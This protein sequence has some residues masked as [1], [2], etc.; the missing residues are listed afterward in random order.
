MLIHHLN[1]IINQTSSNM[2]GSRVDS[3]A[4]KIDRAPFSNNIVQTH[5]GLC[6]SHNSFPLFVLFLLF[7]LGTGDE[8][9]PGIMDR[10]TVDSLRQHV[11]S[12]HFDR[13]PFRPARSHGRG[14]RIFFRNC[15]RR[16]SRREKNRSMEGRCSII[17]L[18]RKRPYLSR[19]PSDPWAHYEPVPRISVADDNRERCSGPSGGRANRFKGQLIPP[20]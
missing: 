17:L 5:T 15:K 14:R 7:S 8:R 20:P 2:K 10:I 4:L 3:G 13:K 1:F 11:Q 6:H 19:P 12:I 18:R 16:D 9:T